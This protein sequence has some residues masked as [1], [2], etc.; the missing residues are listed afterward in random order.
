ME[1]SIDPPLV[2]PA[3]ALSTVPLPLPLEPVLSRLSNEE[4]TDKNTKNRESKKERKSKRDRKT[5]EREKKLNKDKCSC[6]I[7]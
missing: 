3:T 6:G 5:R 1:L 7:R 2:L 4:V